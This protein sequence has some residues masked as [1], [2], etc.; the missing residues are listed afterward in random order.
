MGGAQMSSRAN[1]N[2][3]LGDANASS[4]DFM[5]HAR[6]LSNGGNVRIRTIDD[7]SILDSQ[8]LANK[9]HERL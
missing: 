3:S 2:M 9:I 1:I 7:R 6:D 4:R 8:S 5:R